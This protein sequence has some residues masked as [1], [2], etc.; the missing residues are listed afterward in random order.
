[1]TDAL[2]YFAAG[3]G[4]PAAVVAAPVF[5]RAST[6][7]GQLRGLGYDATPAGT[8][9]H[10]LAAAFNRATSPRLAL[11][12]LDSDIGQPLLRETLWQLRVSDRTA[13]VPVLI[14][15][16]APH[17]AYAERVAEDFDFT[18]AA[19]R[20]RT[21][22]ALGELVERTLALAEEQ[23]PAVEIRSDQAAQALRWIA[24]SLVTKAPYDEL[25]RDADL[26]TL[27]LF[28]PELT[29]P[30]LEV[31]AALGTADSQ[32]L[33]ADY[34][35]TGTLPL[36]NRRAAAAAF[37]ASLKQV[38]TQLTI[39]ELQRQYD[40]YNASE[41]ADADA[42]QVLGGILDALETRN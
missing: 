21:D 36:E 19:P 18:L 20:P 7:A 11:V 33:L 28:D 34:A 40:R 14:A 10:A 42:Q 25:H 22:A 4:E 35:S 17:L 37:A 5:T 30:S 26:V 1:V 15:A 29:G 32:L 16:S 41:S 3:A 13:R 23:L 31:L 6:W 12:V 8:G 39:V 9:N 27:T 24:E 38:G 2:W